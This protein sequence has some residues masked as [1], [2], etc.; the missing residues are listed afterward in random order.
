MLGPRPGADSMSNKGVANES[1]RNSEQIVVNPPKLGLETT[2]KKNAANGAAGH[3]R[4]L[5]REVQHNNAG[6]GGSGRNLQNR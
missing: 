4:R 6:A 1:A 5:S 2:S 3:K